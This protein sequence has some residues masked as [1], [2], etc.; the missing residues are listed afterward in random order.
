MK[1]NKGFTLIEILIV[2]AIISILAS[3]VLVGLGA[4]RGRGRDAR[5]IS[6][7][8][9]TQNALELYYTKYQAYPSISGGDSWVSLTN[10]LSGAGIG[11]TVI[12]NDPLKPT[13]TYHYGVSGDNQKYVLAA[14]LEDS[15]NP[16]L[17]DDTD[18]TIYGIS[19]DD[20]AYCVQF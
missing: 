15:N 7:L 13:K 3:I 5:R 10:S 1:K 18:G 2:V 4:F 9:S 19:C 17:K 20:P 14:D 12:P 11:V 8:R 6:D 16:S